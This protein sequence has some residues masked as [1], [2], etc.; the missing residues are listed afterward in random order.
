MG[1]QGGERSDSGLCKEGTESNG[2]VGRSS[3]SHC[4]REVRA[5]SKPATNMATQSRRAKDY[6]MALPPEVLA[7]PES[8]RGLWG[9]QEG[10]QILGERWET[11]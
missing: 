8:R 1:I 9:Y 2:L 7:S 4:Q 5:W 3:P 6:A 10:R 11:V